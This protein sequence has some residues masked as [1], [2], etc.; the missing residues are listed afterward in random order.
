MATSR[1]LAYDVALQM[2]SLAAQQINAANDRLDRMLIAA[3]AMLP[4]VPVVMLGSGRQDLA[5]DAVAIRAAGGWAL[6]LI[7]TYVVGSV[8]GRVY[9]LAPGVLNSAEWQRTPE[10]FKDYLLYYAE[11]HQ[12]KMAATVLHKRRCMLAMLVLLVLQA[13]SLIVWA[14]QQVAASPAPGAALV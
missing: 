14:A 9:G 4:L 3:V 11:E 10:E 1:D 6:L 5:L 8:R 12:A 13:I 7:V 2:Y